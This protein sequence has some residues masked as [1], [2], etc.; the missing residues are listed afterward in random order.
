MEQRIQPLPIDPAELN[1]LSEKSAFSLKWLPVVWRIQ[2][3]HSA[4]ASNSGP[5]WRSRAALSRITACNFFTNAAL[6]TR[7]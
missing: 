2:C 3:V 6:Q 4:A 5:R 7:Y 1:G